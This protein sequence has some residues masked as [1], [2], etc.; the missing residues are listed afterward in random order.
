MVHKST[1]EVKIA[2]VFHISTTGVRVY[3]EESSTL[4]DSFA[5]DKISFVGALK[6]DKKVRTNRLE[7]YGVNP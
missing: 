7:R 1:K 5:I 6:S 2:I 4:R 3:E